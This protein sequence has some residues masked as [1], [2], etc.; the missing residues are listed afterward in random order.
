[1]NRSRLIERRLRS[2]RLTAPAPSIAA[3][4]EHML[5]TQ[6]QE[7][8]GGRWAL[9]ART[10]GALTVRDADAAFDRGQIVRSWTM[11]G[12]I[13]A[14]PARDLAWVLS[15]TGERQH[16]AA[17]ATHRAEG[18]DADE[19]AKAERVALDAL[20]GGNRLT[21][22]ELFAVLEGA[23]ISTAAQRGY[24]LLVAL[25][26]R[27]LIC[28]G[29][30][31]PRAGGPTREQYVVR[32]DEWVRDAASPADPP[33]E[34]FAR[35]IGS[36]GPAGARDFAWWSGLPLGAARAA[37]DAA[38]ERLSI[39]SG[40]TEP[41]YVAAGPPPRR[42]SAVHDVLA[43]P[44]FEEYYLSYADRTVPCAPEFLSRIGPSMNGIVRPIL[45]VRGRIVGVWTHSVAV[46]RHADAPLPELF[47]PAAASE[48]EVAA[49]LDRYRAFITA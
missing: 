39:V 43:L 44:P 30:V 18:I 14:I 12:T 13:H 24:H 48:A 11:R 33:A 47:A 20:R 5:A 3:A 46:G 41:M 4:A 28:Q 37:A 15:V 9:A 38:S 19:L 23:G 22:K 25:S 40:D 17:A 21:R 10:R 35:F 31:V 8:W 45:L 26:L 6:A 29:P 16:R 34:L 1:M 49:A 2:H 7:F 36:H 32:T 27:A 42:S